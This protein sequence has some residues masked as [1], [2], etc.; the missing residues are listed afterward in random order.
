MGAVFD[1]ADA[2]DVALAP[3]PP[4]LAAGLRLPL[5]WLFL[6]GARFTAG[7]GLRPDTFF[8]GRFFVVDLPFVAAGDLRA[9]FTCFFTMV[10]LVR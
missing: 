4:F 6:A 3:A 10:V 8:G 7:A 2:L 9:G 5:G 1:L